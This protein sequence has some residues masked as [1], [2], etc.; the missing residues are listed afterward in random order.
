MSLRRLGGT[1]FMIDGV[2]W[3]GWQ[4]FSMALTY[5]HQTNAIKKL[6]VSTK[7]TFIKVWVVCATWWTLGNFFGFK[8]PIRNEY[9][10]IIISLHGR[11]NVNSHQASL[12]NSLRLKK[13]GRTVAV[14][15]I[16]NIW[17][18]NSALSVSWWFTRPTRTQFVLQQ[19]LLDCIW[20]MSF[21][22]LFILFIA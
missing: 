13:Y 20:F 5:L 8:R 10:I 3:E 22:N 4:L 11:L 21:F 9:T 19:P 2:K 17:F 1:S 16:S 12:S 6:P 7:V 14:A 15:T 18:K